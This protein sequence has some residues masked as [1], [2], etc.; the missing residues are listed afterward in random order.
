MDIKQAKKISKALADDNRLQILKEIRS[1]SN[2]LHC[3]DIHEFINLSQPSISHH[4]KQLMEA[5]LII[6]EKEGRKMKY[7]INQEVLDEY[8]AFLDELKVV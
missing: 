6:H 1:K 7:R 2:C 5:D 8:I 3:T 4:I